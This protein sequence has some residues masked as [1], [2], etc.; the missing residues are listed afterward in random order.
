L[1]AGKVEID[2]R[3]F[4][5]DKSAMFKQVFRHS[6]MLQTLI[7]LLPATVF[8]LSL[9]ARAESE[10]AARRTLQSKP[11]EVGD[12]AL[13]DQEGRFHQLRRRTDSRALVL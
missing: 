5:L 11:D 7:V 4:C 2:K 10:E 1:R 8:C 3:R 6:R 13:L 12:F 9:P